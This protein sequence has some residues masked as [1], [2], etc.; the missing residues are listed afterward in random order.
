MS[1]PLRGVSVTFV[2]THVGPTGTSGPLRGVCDI[3]IRLDMAY[4]LL[5]E[6]DMCC[7]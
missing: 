7:L 4:V 2:Y 1:G 6:Y 5:K 3:L